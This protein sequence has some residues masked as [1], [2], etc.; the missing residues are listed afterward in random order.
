MRDGKIIM[1]VLI[2]DPIGRAIAM[3][4]AIKDNYRNART[5]QYGLQG[6]ENPCTGCVSHT[7]YLAHWNNKGEARGRGRHK[8]N[9]SKSVVRN[10][11]EK[12]LG[13][14]REKNPKQGL[15][16]AK[17]ITIGHTIGQAN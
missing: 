7:G 11:K 3:L 1:V 5:I 10:M 2:F 13:T 4:P 9:N 14:I 8:N 12:N 16:S 6:T 17:D 15:T